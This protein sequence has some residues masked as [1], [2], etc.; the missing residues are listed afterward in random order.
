MSLVDQKILRGVKISVDGTG[1]DYI[2]RTVKATLLWKG[3]T[4]RTGNARN[5]I[6]TLWHHIYFEISSEDIEQIS[7]TANTRDAREINL[8][9]K[10][11]TNHT[12]LI[13]PDKDQAKNFTVVA[14]QPQEEQVLMSYNRGA[15]DDEDRIMAITRDDVSDADI[16][17]FKKI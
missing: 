1:R 13:Y 12:V 4:W 16:E 9:L 14:Y 7:N 11:T 8:D 15:R 2:A 10:D 6:N 3:Q 5:H 17:W